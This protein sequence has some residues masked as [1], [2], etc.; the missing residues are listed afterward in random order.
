[1]CARSFLNQ[2]KRS[3]LLRSHT[4]SFVTP[5]TKTMSLVSF[6]NTKK[7][8]GFVKLVWNILCGFREPELLPTSGFLVIQ[9]PTD[10]PP[11]QNPAHN[12]GGAI[13]PQGGM[14][15]QTG[16]GASVVSQPNLSLSLFLYIFILQY[17]FK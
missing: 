6:N 12:T 7:F 9:T 2:T 15:G 4:F 17:S 16:R 11:A 10:K 5:S 8:K 13:S 14:A 3:P 1:M